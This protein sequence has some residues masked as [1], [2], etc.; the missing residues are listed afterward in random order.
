MFD[1][2][3]QISLNIGTSTNMKSQNTLHQRDHMI[4][5]TNSP[6]IN[7]KPLLDN[8]TILYFLSTFNND[9][10]DFTQTHKFKKPKKIDKQL[11]TNFLIISRKGIELFKVFYQQCG[12]YFAVQILN[13]D[14]SINYKEV[15]VKL[16]KLKRKVYV[17]NNPL[18]ENKDSIIPIQ[19]NRGIME[20]CDFYNNKSV[21]PSMRNPITASLFYNVSPFNQKTINRNKHKIMNP[22]DSIIGVL[23][24]F[25]GMLFIFNSSEPI[26]EKQF[27]FGVFSWLTPYFNDIVSSQYFEYAA[28]IE[29][30]ATFQV[31]A[32]Y[33]ICVPLLIYRNSGIPLGILV[34]PSEKFSL[35]SMF[36]ESLKKLDNELGNSENDNSLFKKFQNKK[37]LS[38]EHKAFQKLSKEY[39]LEF[40]NCFVHLIRSIGANSLLGF[41]LS[42]ILYTFSGDEWSK[43][44]FRYFHILKQLYEERNEKDEYRF[45]K[46]SQVLGINLKGQSIPMKKEY[47]P[48]FIRKE[49]IIPT[50]TNHIESFHKQLNG[51]I[52]GSRLSLPL[53]FAYIIKYIIDRTIRCN[54]NAQ[55]N[56]KTHF[57]RIKNIAKKA[58]LQNPDSIINYSKEICFCDKDWYYSAVYNIIIPCVHC[59][60]SDDFD[61]NAYLNK[62]KERDIELS[63]ESKLNQLKI[64]NI[65]TNLK[66]IKKK[67]QNNSFNDDITEIDMKSIDFYIEQ[68]KEDVITKIINNSEYQLSDI[69]KK[70]NLNFTVI[71]LK[72]QRKL[73]LED[74]N[75][76]RLQET[77]IDAFYA[78]FQISL[79]HEILDGREKIEI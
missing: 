49:N 10:F 52:N 20:L 72:V 9:I 32:P 12:N 62:M 21:D 70:H 22:D 75:A 73:L 30:D 57:N 78:L 26:D 56:L 34:S 15:E 45:E 69:I 44:I 53:R 14:E 37:Y 59:I 1:Q 18:I 2:N 55:E 74:E 54:L 27:P 63:K 31:L 46:V 29:L 61:A 7:T 11:F 64:Y 13:V 6:Y 8:F 35:Y 65:D 3:G 16:N 48:L 43:N 25:G 38:D 51:I 5:L 36:F 39:N 77:N 67:V 42:D 33:K 17:Y 24:N 66:F 50:T 19:A 60:L 71:A 40:Y 76:K 47:S 28:T 23:E 41:L 58:V 68:S 79:W 4:F